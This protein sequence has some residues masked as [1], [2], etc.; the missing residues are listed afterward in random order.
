MKEDR[1]TIYRLTGATLAGLYY[2]GQVVL[3]WIVLAY[4]WGNRG[5]TDAILGWLALAFIVEK[6]VRGSSLIAR[7]AVGKTNNSAPETE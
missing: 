4:L 3:L 6:V 5:M 7:F 1:H 2:G